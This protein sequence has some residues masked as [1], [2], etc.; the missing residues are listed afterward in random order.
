MAVG[1]CLASLILAVTLSA[2]ERQAAPAAA[3]AIGT[4]KALASDGVTVAT[5][6]GAEVKVSVLPVTRMLQTAPGE[7]DLTKA[8]PIQLGQ[9][10]V[11]DRVL[12]RGQ[13]V[14]GVLAATSFIVMKKS[15]VAQV[16]QKEVDDW[17]KRGIG[18]LVSAVDPAA[19]TV[20][21][22]AA[23]TGGTPTTVHVGK[24]T[25]IRRYAP[26]SIKFDDAAKAQLDSVHPG[27]QLRARGNR[28][29]DGANFNAEE[30]VSGT[31]RNI[32]GLIS[33]IDS[34]HGTITLTDLTTKKPVTV[35]IGPD[36]QLRKIPAQAAQF[37]ALRLRS[38]EAAAAAGNGGGGAP[39]GAGP[40]GQ[41]RG[42]GDMQQMLN[43]LPAVTLAELQKGDAVMMVTTP[44]SA[45]ADMVAVTLLSGVEAILTA[46][47]TASLLTPW[48]LSG[49]GGD[50]AQ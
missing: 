26:D 16:R 50:A 23:A 32:S 47:N 46:P 27:D 40:Q 19:G 31:F 29:A 42:G 28:S 37:I 30:I 17:Q 21:L 3:R 33:S 25:V 38:P 8:T 35:K 9:V 14:S 48:N 44:G 34:E 7:T 24:D 10:Q 20:T 39:G 36:S 2:S 5:D 43:R 41:R 49:G 13:N 18:G 15:D 22:A 11:G 1:V 6:A 4:V 45:S 12:V